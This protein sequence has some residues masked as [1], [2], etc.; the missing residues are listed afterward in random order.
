MQYRHSHK[1]LE[2]G[3]RL[4]FLLWA[5]PKAHLLMLNFLISVPGKTFFFLGPS[6]AQAFSRTHDFL[7]LLFRGVPG[8]E[9]MVARLH[10][11]K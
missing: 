11:D 10:S 9:S 1:K 8:V 2:I 3:L 4:T 5:R 7:V 6:S